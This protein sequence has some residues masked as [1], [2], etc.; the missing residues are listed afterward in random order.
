MAE[1]HARMHLRD[2]VRDDDVDRAIQVTLHSFIHAQKFSVMRSLERGF[3][4]YLTLKTDHHQLLMHLLQELVKDV[5]VYAQMR[6]QQLPDQF[7]IRCDDLEAKAK[8][9]SVYRLE[10]FY[11]SDIFTSHQF[12]YDAETKIITKRF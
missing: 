9:Y 10:S 11:E 12:Q 3:Q 2:A 5:G 8:K 6:R 4:K 7:E 1:A